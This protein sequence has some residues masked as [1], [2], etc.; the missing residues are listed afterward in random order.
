MVFLP[1][2]KTIVTIGVGIMTSFALF[3]PLSVASVSNSPI[4]QVSPSCAY[5]QAAIGVGTHNSHSVIVQQNCD[6]TQSTI[7]SDL[8][9]S[10]GTLTLRKSLQLWKRDGQ[11]LPA[12]VTESGSTSAGGGQA[13]YTSTIDSGG[14]VTTTE[15]N[16]TWD[17]VSSTY[18]TSSTETLNLNTGQ[19]TFHRVIRQ[20]AKGNCT[21]SNWVS[22]VETM[23]RTAT[24]PVT[25]TLRLFSPTI[26]ISP[27]SQNVAAGQSV[28]L[29]VAAT[30]AVPDPLVYQWYEGV[31]GDESK[32][33]GAK[34]SSFTTPSLTSNTNYWVKVSNCGSSVASDTAMIAVGDSCNYLQTFIKTGLHNVH[35]VIVQQNCDGTQSTSASDLSVT[36]ATLTLKSLPLIKRDGQWLP[37]TVTVTAPTSAGGGQATYTS[38]VDSAG[39]VTT[40]E[41]NGTW[42]GVSSTYETSSTETL[43]LNT[44]QYT[45]HRVIR[46]TAKGSCTTSNWISAVENHDRTAFLPISSIL[47]SF[48]PAITTSPVSQK[49]PSGQTVTLS[50]GATNPVADPLTYQWYEGVSGDQSKP[51]G[52]NSS[53][54]TSPAL[55]SNKSYW[56]RVRNCSTSVNSTTAM[57]TVTVGP[58]ITQQPS[59][60]TIRAFETAK[61]TVV[62][63]GDN[64]KYQ[65]YEGLPGTTTK[66]VGVNAPTFTTPELTKSTK[67]WVRVSNDNGSV[68]SIAAT[69]TVKLLLLGLEV[70]QGIQDL[71][72]HVP[73]IAE[74]RTMVRALVSTG[75][76]D[77]RNVVDVT[78]RLTT[79]ASTLT[80]G[81]KNVLAKPSRV[82]MLDSFNFELPLAW[83]Q[84]EYNLELQLLDY[85]LDCSAP[86]IRTST[87]CKTTVRFI[88]SPDLL[89]NLVPITYS[90]DGQSRS[91]SS[92]ELDGVCEELKAT[93]PAPRVIC[94][95][96]P[97]LSIPAPPRVIT[98]EQDDYWPLN[99]M[100]QQLRVTSPAITIGVLT[101]PQTGDIRFGVFYS[102]LPD[103]VSAYTGDLAGPS[104]EVGHLLGMD[105]VNSFQAE[106]VP[107]EAYPYLRG[108]LSGPAASGAPVEAGYFG[109]DFRALF[110]R[111]LL[112]GSRTFDMM[113]Y[114]EP[115]WISDFTFKK[116]RSGSAR[117]IC[118]RFVGGFCIPFPGDQLQTE[119]SQKRLSLPA[120]GTEDL[121]AL[122]S[123]VI[124]PNGDAGHLEPVY[125]LNGGGTTGSMTTGTYAIRLETA[126]GQTL[127]TYNFDPG[128]SSEGPSDRPFV[129]ALPFNQQTRKV[130]LLHN[131]QVLATRT[132]SNNVPNVT[133][134][135]PNG[136]ENLTGQTTTVTWSA[137][138]LDN[139]TLTF[140]LQYSR[141]N[142]TTWQ[143]VAVNLKGS[144]HQLDLNAIPG[145]SQARVRIIA[146]DGFNTAMDQSDGVITVGRHAPQVTIDS[147]REQGSFF[148]DQTILFEGSALDLEDGSLGNSAF[149]WTS[150][151][152]GALG[153]GPALTKTAAS[154]VPGTHLIRMTARDGDNT[155]GSATVTIQVAAQRPVL[156]PT[157]SVA[158]TALS[159]RVAVGG[160][161][162]DTQTIAIRNAG[163]SSL[164]WSATSDQQ[165]LQVSSPNGSAPSNITVTANATGLA[166]G[167]YQGHVLLS[168]AGA[169]NGQQSLATELTV[170][171]ASGPTI[172]IEEGTTNQAAAIDSVTFLRGPF[173]VLNLFNFSVDH[174]T[175]VI[176]F[177]SDL[178]LS[179][180]DSSQLTVKA[181]GVGLTVEAV[182]PI[183]G[184]SGLSGSFIVVRLPDGLPTG[185]LPLIVTLRGSPS[186]NSPILPISP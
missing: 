131:N 59:D 43:N 163:D 77:A 8:S 98:E 185:N 115:S 12:T 103:V 78:A 119:L 80:D 86:L 123:G 135:A 172:F 1:P 48:S 109:F 148:G 74:R 146:T 108:L 46:Q 179:L 94:A 102:N 20:T 69:V 136:G 14:T 72:N 178:G 58:Q 81:P 4:V 16:G 36:W 3:Y 25:L 22:A 10:F 124:S 53:T 162:S 113:S 186:V 6:G 66:P 176:L 7:P 37:A 82:Q 2:R 141:D 173:R 121:T 38:T 116:I 49:V 51:V 101:R 64:L 133:I 158:P 118:N 28:I 31:K 161:L 120:L 153:T 168:A 33:V 44:G 150:N 147:P 34:A 55:S 112:P 151:L 68:D 61:L 83:R 166:P 63:T 164:N 129:F 57:I 18:E 41:T 145:S 45:F 125:L 165:W 100:L 13:T 67:Y 127:F 155:V 96:A 104:H 128:S 152:S 56:V 26:I 52:T 97:G 110:D 137:T 117:S 170:L 114:G 88:S 75:S 160:P 149:S 107:F 73:L 99:M 9:V 40:N 154:L 91:P 71:Q 50:V 27:K 17:G 111:P 144:S 132:A 169:I 180:P 93:M 171:A 143:T 19:Y 39:M 35:N 90:E 87:G 140:M 130:S 79:S 95:R 184:V 181:G 138:D 142:G 70:T 174:H 21:T 15:T 134:T 24:L 177:T 62:A 139:D 106:A 167:K 126:Q 65:W 122:I 23:D 47:T 92:S 156:P 159:F 76:T 175:R 105:H 182:G 89:V 84:G 85:E 5:R 54:F 157:L 42:D 30:N 60:Q 11:F 183:Q 32:P 29:T